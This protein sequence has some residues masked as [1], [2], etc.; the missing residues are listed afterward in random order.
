MDIETASSCPYSQLQD[1][2]V[3]EIV[4]RIET[5][6]GARHTIRELAA[7]VNLSES[8]LRHLFRQHTGIPL[9][10]FIA[11]QRLQRAAELLEGS[12]D[13][14]SEVAFQTSFTNVAQFDKAF[15][16]HFGRTPTEYRCSLV[17]ERE[18]LQCAA[19]SAS[20]ADR[21]A[22]EDKM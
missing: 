20:Y 5:N 15:R 8:R 21:T 9:A 14:V 19:T 6:P 10:R 1:R 13:R 4:R 2:R 18:V 16:A 7:S 22:E 12:F 11:S 17:P 3:R